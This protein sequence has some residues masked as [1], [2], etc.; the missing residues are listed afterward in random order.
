VVVNRSIGGV[1]IGDARAEVEE[2][3][4]RPASTVALALGGQDGRLLRYRSHG[5]PLLVTLDATGRVVSIEAYAAFF[6]TAGG[7]GPGS[8]LADVRGLPG[9]RVDYCRYGYWNGSAASPPGRVV[10]V[11]TP[12][13]DEVES[14]LI[15]Q[16]RLYTACAGGSPELPPP[17]GVV[18]NRSLAGVSLGMTQ[19]RVVALLG[20]PQSTL[21]LSL[22]PG[23]A[24]RLVRYRLQGAPLLVVYDGAGRVVSLETW[25]TAFRTAGDV[26]PGASLAQVRRLRGFRPDYCQLGWWNGTARTRPRDVVTVFTPSGGSVASVLITQY[27]LYTACATGSL[28]LPPT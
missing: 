7:V 6:R 26:G 5:A 12:A 17:V 18:P 22:G 4:G 16:L 27:R 8:P 25:S 10:T 21:G 15:T 23:Q 1:S 3:L 24:G 19:A 11:F 14:V 13:G 28:E 20:R 9:F 2:A